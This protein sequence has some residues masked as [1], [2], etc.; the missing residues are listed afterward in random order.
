M[1]SV[2]WESLLRQDQPPPPGKKAADYLFENEVIE[3]YLAP[4]GIEEGSEKK[5]EVVF[6]MDF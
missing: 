6:Q 2:T 5:R 4:E 3:M 1:L